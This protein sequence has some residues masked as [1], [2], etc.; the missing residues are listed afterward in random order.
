MRKPAALRAHLVAAMPELAR[1]ADRLLI[2][3]DA[4]SMPTTFA[5]GLSFQYSYTLNLIVTDMADDPDH[6]M[7]HASEWI[8]AEQ[9]ELM[10]NPARRE[11]MRFEV[12]VL[13]NDKFDLSLKLPVTERVIVTKRDDGS[14][15][16]D[17]PPEPQIP[18]DWI[19]SGG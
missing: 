19:P 1:D 18:A 9:P 8:R 17:N 13:A 14:V 4:G 11:E 16:F 3:V 5:P 12:D 2:F 15:Q 7:F 6:L 10:A